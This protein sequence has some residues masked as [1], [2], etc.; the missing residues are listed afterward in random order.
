MEEDARELLSAVNRLCEG[1]LWRILDEE[2]LRGSL[3]QGD[4]A[5]ISA[6]LERLDARGLIELRYADGGTYCVRAMPAGRA[7]MARMAEERAADRAREHR[8]TLRAFLG[9]FAGAFAGALLAGLL[10]L[11]W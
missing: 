1:T 4:A 7:Y 5:D 2:E 11:L 6:L 3:P 9:A 8:L 10:S